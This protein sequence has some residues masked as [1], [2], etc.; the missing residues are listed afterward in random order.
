MICLVFSSILGQHQRQNRTCIRMCNGRGKANAQKDFFLG[1]DPKHAAGQIL[2]SH[3]PITVRMC[4]KV[5]MIKSVIRWSPTVAVYPNSPESCRVR[6]CNK[7]WKSCTDH[8]S[9]CVSAEAALLLSGLILCGSLN[10]IRTSVENWGRRKRPRWR[11]TVFLA[12]SLN[13]DT[14]CVP[15]S[16]QAELQS[17]RPS[18][19]LDMDTTLVT[20]KAPGSKALL[21]PAMSSKWYLAASW[22]ATWAWY[23]TISTIRLWSV[24]AWANTS[25]LS[26][27]SL[28][29]LTSV[30]L[31]G[32]TADS[33]PPNRGWGWPALPAA[34]CISTWRL[35][36][37]LEE[38][39]RTQSL[40]LITHSHQNTVFWSKHTLDSGIRNYMSVNA[41]W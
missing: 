26:G 19:D 11:V 36:A 7:H 20:S 28:S 33:A 39:Q 16:I 10:V 35:R 14:H 1:W 13:L 17:D 2:I 21:L 22:S 9:L 4:L 23:S 37:A 34:L 27:I 18:S 38:Q 25:W 8:G 41:A 29:S 24:C 12:S 30:V 3:Q 40:F 5:P 15:V 32:R 6:V 31:W